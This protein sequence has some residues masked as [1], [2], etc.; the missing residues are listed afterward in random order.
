MPVDVL[1]IVAKGDL[2][3]PDECVSPCGS[4]RQ[5]VAESERRYRKSMKVILVSEGGRSFVFDRG[6]DLLIF[7]F[8]M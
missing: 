2:I 5:V 8:G 4:C 1:V 6:V 3:G 7:P